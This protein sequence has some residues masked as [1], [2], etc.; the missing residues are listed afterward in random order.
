MHSHYDDE[1]RRRAHAKPRPA[2]LWQTAASASCSPKRGARYVRPRRRALVRATAIRR[3]T[4]RSAAQLRR[5]NAARALLGFVVPVT[6]FVARLAVLRILPATR[7]TKDLIR[8]SLSMVPMMRLELI[9]LSPPPP[10]DGV[11]TNSTTSALKPDNYFGMSLALESLSAAGAAGGW[12]AGALSA[13]VL[14]AGAAG[15]SLRSSI[16][17]LFSLLWLE[18]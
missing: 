6:T 3:A 17:P 10:Q 7:L 14:S 1:R 13:D 18:M 4:A 12:L 11:S 8:G 9:R 2:G 5:C 15:A 16:T